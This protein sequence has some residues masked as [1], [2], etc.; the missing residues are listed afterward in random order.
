VISVLLVAL[1]LV[2]PASAKPTRIAVFGSC[3]G[4]QVT[5]TYEGADGAYQDSIIWAELEDGTGLDSAGIVPFGREDTLTV[6]LSWN[7]LPEGTVVVIFADHLIA[8]GPNAG[9]TVDSVSYACGEP[10]VMPETGNI[11]QI[12]ADMAVY[13][14]PD[15][16]FP[17]AGTLVK[18]GQEFPLLDT[19]VAGDMT[20][21]QIWVGS[22]NYPWVPAVGAVAG[23]K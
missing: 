15:L 18:A 6:T 13:S 17:I 11:A 10:V 3:E 4:A 22:N 23:S 21:Y 16:N 9:L 20:W 1:V 8:S 5:V 12:T 19:E 2:M 7:K 14:Q